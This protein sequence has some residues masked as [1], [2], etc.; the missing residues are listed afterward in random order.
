MYSFRRFTVSAW[1]RRSTEG[2]RPEVA[3]PGPYGR[4]MR[5]PKAGRKSVSP[6]RK[7]SRTVRRPTPNP[8]LEWLFQRMADE[9]PGLLRAVS[10]SNEKVRLRHTVL[11]SPFEQ[12]VKDFTVAILR[13]DVM[14]RRGESVDLVTV[15]VR[16]LPSVIVSRV[17]SAV[18]AVAFR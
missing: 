1:Y 4:E 11:I 9:A 12:T 14:D 6:L 17:P 5:K 7:R 8:L 3:A 10:W 16:G 2:P 18:L 13:P 15:Q